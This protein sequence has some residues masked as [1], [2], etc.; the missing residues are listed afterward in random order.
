[1]LE[2]WNDLAPFD[3][4]LIGG[5]I[6]ALLTKIANQQLSVLPIAAFF[7]AAAVSVI[8]QPDGAESIILSER[9]QIFA[10]GG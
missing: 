9:S 5:T 10:L 2:V 3:S 4:R 8:T 6:E 7:V 1:M